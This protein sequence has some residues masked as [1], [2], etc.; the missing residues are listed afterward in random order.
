MCRHPGLAKSSLQLLTYLPTRVKIRFMSSPSPQP[1][2]PSAHTPGLV[3]LDRL[4]N[5]PR[6]AVAAGVGIALSAGVL[7]LAG[8]PVAGAIVAGIGAACLGGWMAISFQ[9]IISGVYKA[10]KVS[11]RQV[12]DLVVEVE[13]LEAET[14]EVRH[15]ASHHQKEALHLRHELDVER[16]RVARLERFDQLTGLPNRTELL[17][18]SA[19]EL[20][21]AERH[22]WPV[23]ALLIDIDRFRE[24]NARYGEDVGDQVLA[25]VA[26]RLSETRRCTDVLGRLGGEEFVLLAPDTRSGQGAILARRIRDALRE[27]PIEVDGQ[28]ITVTLSIGI[29]E[30]PNGKGNLKALLTQADHALY[31]AKRDGRDRAVVR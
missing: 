16:G 1:V 9:Q 18:Q 27:R 30:S 26:E 10:A 8:Q 6:I 19:Q 17:S 21:R 14:E 11:V 2:S 4:Y 13:R 29:S 20:A 3:T 5:M 12:D 31:E 23:S 24:V 28:E 15:E 25:Q 7:V 22:R